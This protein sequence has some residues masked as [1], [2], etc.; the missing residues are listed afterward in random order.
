MVQETFT[1][2]DESGLHARPASIISNLASQTLCDVDILY[3]GKRSTLKSIM[4]VMSLAIPYK[5][6]FTIEVS[7]EDESTV[8]ENIVA[9]LKKF[10]IV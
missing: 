5:A 1:V 6:E 10:E 9:V 8:L 2:K 3:K 7:G 4:V